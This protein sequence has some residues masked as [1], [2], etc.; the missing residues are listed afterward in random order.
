MNFPFSFDIQ[1]NISLY[2][3]GV[4]EPEIQPMF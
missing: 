3:F 1:I 2:L 4:G